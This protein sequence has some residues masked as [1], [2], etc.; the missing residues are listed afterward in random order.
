MKN[1]QK[2][3]LPALVSLAGLTAFEAQA[4]TSAGA[5]VSN[6]A[7]LN[8]SV[9]GAAQ[10]EVQ[11]L[12]TLLVDAKVDFEVTQATADG[13]HSTSEQ[14]TIDSTVYYVVG[15][16][17]IS[18]SGNADAT[19]KFS[20][21]DA[22]TFSYGGNAA[23]AP[24]LTGAT[25]VYSLNGTSLLAADSDGDYSVSIVQD[26]SD[27]TVYVLATSAD[28]IGTDGDIMAATLT[29]NVKSVITDELSSAIAV[30]ST[31]SRT[32]AWDKNTVQLVFAD[33][34]ANNIESA[35]DGLKLDNMPDFGTNPDGTGTN[36]AFTKTSEVVWDPFT[37]ALDADNGIYPKAIPDAIVKYTITLNNL[38]SGAASGVTVGDTLPTTLAYCSA[39]PT[40]AST[41]GISCALNASAPTNGTLTD[42]AATTSVS[43]NVVTVTY[44]T[45]S[46]GYTSTITF[47]A[48]VQ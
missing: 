39:T 22:Q 15:K 47:Y 33:D 46:G 21:A 45:F 28:A 29:A 8:Y 7:T 24:D 31:D 41:D 32:A 5:T 30:G 20:A 18:N 38:G 44:S 12:N 16:Y 25:Y 17:D 37:G 34:G 48:I 42:S 14:V 2:L 13:V 11:A 4:E 23:A 6:S 1:I 26:G 35:T 9:N 19:F 43:G 27:A 40:E 36:S 3:V 10:N